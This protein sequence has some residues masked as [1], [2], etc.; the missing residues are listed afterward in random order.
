MD[1]AHYRAEY[2]RAL[3]A[4]ELVAMPDA[5]RESLKRL[6]GIT[7]ER[8]YNCGRVSSHQGWYKG[9]W[10]A[11]TCQCGHRFSVPRGKRGRY[12]C[13]CCADRAEGCY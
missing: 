11:D 8:P 9:A 1:Q 2:E 3:A 7:P 5:R 13:D 4:G 12:V 6:A 10:A